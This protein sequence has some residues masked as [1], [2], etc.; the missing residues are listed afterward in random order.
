[1]GVVARAAAKNRKI[2]ARTE[3]AAGATTLCEDISVPGLDW[4]KC[5]SRIY[6]EGAFMWRSPH[7]PASISSRLAL[8]S[9]PSFQ[10]RYKI[11]RFLAEEP[12]NG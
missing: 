1:M 2:P 12:K 6:D 7:P 8:N 10:G 4:A 11:E 3:A 9:V 5:R